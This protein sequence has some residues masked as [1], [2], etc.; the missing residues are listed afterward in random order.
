MIIP[1]QLFHRTEFIVN[2]LDNVLSCKICWIVDGRYTGWWLVFTNLGTFI[3]LPEQSWFQTLPI[4]TQ[5]HTYTNTRILLRNFC[6]SCTNKLYPPL[7]VRPHQHCRQQATTHFAMYSW[8]TFSWWTFALCT[9][10]VG[11]QWSTFIQQFTRL[12]SKH[13]LIA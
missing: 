11:G 10:L 7:D 5:E 6:Q 12:Y 13:L 9:G 2:K 3:P 8:W 1:H 4:F